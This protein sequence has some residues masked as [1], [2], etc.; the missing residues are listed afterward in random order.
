MVAGMSD[1]PA[2]NAMDE[3]WA[4]LV[5][6]LPTRWRELATEKGATKGLREDKDE[7]R[8]LRVLLLHLACEY[9]LRETA[10]RA[11]EARLADLSDVALLKRL[12]K[13]KD[14]LHG[15]CRQLLAE[16]AALTPRVDDLA[17]RLVDATLIKELGVT[18][19]AWR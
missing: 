10:V 2:V 13:S 1:I 8:F 18:G 17:L 6:M 14:W 16:H 5:T 4:L 19:S 9:S 15:L 3:D 11:R 12:R 7:E